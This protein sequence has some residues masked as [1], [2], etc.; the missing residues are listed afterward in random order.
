M[1]VKSPL[2]F[3]MKVQGSALCVTSLLLGL[4]GKN[5]A[6]SFFIGGMIYLLPNLYFVYYAFRFRGAEHAVSIARSFVW[7][8]MGKLA[9]SAFGFI[10][11]FRMMPTI[12]HKALFAGF[13]SMIILQW[14][15][16]AKLTHRGDQSTTH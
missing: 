15:V 11:A 13:V 6:Y 1:V 7:G 8:E 5:T 4:W 16:A 12:N 14:L 2:W 10:L 9:L 3:S